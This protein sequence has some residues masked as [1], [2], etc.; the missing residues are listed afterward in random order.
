[1]PA[2]LKLKSRLARYRGRGDLEQVA[3]EDH[4]V[5]IRRG[6]VPGME[7][8]CVLYVPAKYHEHLAGG[9]GEGTTGEAKAEGAAECVLDQ[10]AKLATFKGA[11]SPLVALPDVHAGRDFPVGICAVFDAEA[12]DCVVLPQ[13]IGP[14][15]NC[16]VRVW[17]TNIPLA[18][19]QQRRREVL[20][21]VQQAVPVNDQPLPSRLNIK[22][23]LSDGIDY[24]VELGLAGEP[25]QQ[26]S[27]HRGKMPGSFKALGQKPR[28]AGLKQLGTL[29]SGNH[30][31]EFQ[32]VSEI[33]D[34]GAAGAMSLEADTVCVTVH[35]GSRGVGH[36]ALTE[37]LASLPVEYLVDGVLAVPL[38]SA[39]GAE[40][41]EL[42]GAAANFAFCNR[43]VI[44]RAV[45]QAL[46]QV[47]PGARLTLLGDSPHNIA[48][49]ETHDGRRRL[50]LRKGSTRV[51]PPGQDGEAGLFPGI[52]AP[53]SVGGSMST[54]SY[55]L[56]AGEQSARTN[57]TTCHG[58]GR[59]LGR[60]AAK[61]AISVAETMEQLQAADVLVSAQN[62]GALS[63]ESAKAYKSIDEVVNF[64]E[65]SGISK[66]ICRLLPIMVLKG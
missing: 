9:A 63:E 18:G 42:V 65:R 17:R 40:Y 52:G 62:P 28:A 23:V 56:A 53:V 16:G 46:Q 15:I 60:K 27:E 48:K 19:L 49:L 6:F 59:V 5:V 7:A 25:D 21:L 2:T 8:E 35:T 13:A 44:G 58:S 32:R 43:V 36:R 50:V 14:D 61:T 1:M 37:F 33:Y 51:A 20:A 11:M 39:K 64:C 24:L 3:V 45:E 30:Y 34:P 57:F 38:H 31:L 26:G 55:L 29:G 4:A 54:G 22:R 66:K 41:L 10:L 12:Q 47:F